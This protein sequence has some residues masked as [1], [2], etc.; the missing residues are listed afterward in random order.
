MNDK[1]S[2]LLNEQS[3]EKIFISDKLAMM[4]NMGVAYVADVAI[5]CPVMINTKN[6]RILVPMSNIQDELE[7][8]NFLSVVS[9]IHAMDEEFSQ[10]NLLI[11]ACGHIGFIAFVKK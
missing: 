5:S 10:Q 3:I 4:E 9:G 11:S 1:I 8:N 7:M 2:K 6:P